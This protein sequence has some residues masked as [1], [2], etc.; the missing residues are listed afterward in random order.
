M[1]DRLIRPVRDYAIF[2]IDTNGMLASWNEGVGCI[3]GYTEQEFLGQRASM[4][5]TPEDNLGDAPR[6]EMEQAAREGCASD[7]RWHLRKDGSRFFCDGV[8]T[9][10]R[11]EEGEPTGYTKIMRD[12]TARLAMEQQ[13]AHYAAL[14]A[15]SHDAIAGVTPKGMV[16]S[17]NPAAERMFGYTAAEATGKPLSR[18]VGPESAA[19]G[20]PVVGKE[21]VCLTKDGQALHVS[22][23]LSPIREASGLLTGYSAIFRDI[24]ERRRAE[25]LMAAQARELHRSNDELQ[26]FAYTASHDLQEPIRTVVSLTQLLARNHSGSLGAETDGMISL[27]L[28]AANRMSK[29]VR[30]LL[31]YSRVGAEPELRRQPVNLQD[32]IK[33]TLQALDFAIRDSEAVIRH[34]DLPTVLADEHEMH[35]LLQNLLSNALKYRSRGE[36]PRIDVEASRQAGEWLITIRDDGLGFDPRHAEHIFGIFKRVHG[37]RYPGTGIGLA[38]C[39]KIV[40][41][42]GGR[43]W[44]ESEGHGRGAAFHF[45]LPALADSPGAESGS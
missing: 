19:A 43:I 1:P 17:W 41:R 42:H 24:E 2:V 3:L 10:I 27:I 9:A 37:Q 18:L 6:Q 44:A 4:L 34:H 23:T 7:L 35:Q 20:E 30:G 38:I 33:T 39:R 8:L 28:E 21:T 11:G 16:M 22:V 29:L 12:A 40:E 36:P 14:V 45:T 26:A 13:A 32:T 31:D 5:F 25:Q 15:S